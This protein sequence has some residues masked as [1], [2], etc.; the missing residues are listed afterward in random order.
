MCGE[1][2]L[3]LLGEEPSLV[4]PGWFGSHIV[5][6]KV[7]WHLP[8]VMGGRALLGREQQGRACSIKWHGLFGELGAGGYEAGIPSGTQ[9]HRG[10]GE[11]RQGSDGKGVLNL[12]NSLKFTLWIKGPLD[13]SASGHKL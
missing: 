12:V 11:G 2:R 7:H 4:L 13:R 5:F 8:R 3:N 1:H 6:A 10:V 9:V